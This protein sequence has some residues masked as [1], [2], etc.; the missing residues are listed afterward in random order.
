MNRVF[1]FIG[2]LLLVGILLFSFGCGKPKPP[3][4]PPDQN[5]HLGPGDYTFSLFHAGLTRVYLV[6]VPSSYEYGT[7]IAVILNFHGGGGNAEN[8]AIQ[9]QMNVSS[10]HEGYIAVY[11]NGTGKTV[12]GH[13]FGTWNA[14]RCCGYAKDNAIDD[15]G[16]TSALIDDLESKFSVD[17]KRVFATGHS[18]GA[19]FSYQL[20]CELSDRIAAIAP[21]AA[22]DSVIQCNPSR[23]VPV[24]H[25]HGTADPAALFN[26][27]HCGG[28]LTTDAGW[29]CQSVPDYLNEWRIRNGCSIDLNVT[30]QTGDATCRTYQNCSDNAEV[31]LCT[32][33]GAGHT[34]PDGQYAGLGEALVGK[35][36]R[37]ISA[38]AEMWKFFQAHPLP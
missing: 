9:S 28:R 13:L 22:Q 25:F 37:D 38:N 26:G 21:N 34:W 32:M 30:Y 11:P 10:N 14:G 20:A 29:D 15:V 6:H 24:M 33:E 2:L 5:I 27:G 17:S 16:F 7:P 31:V 8:Q 19:L 35:I 18:N 23:K 36:S 3:E 1:K 4:P 12:A